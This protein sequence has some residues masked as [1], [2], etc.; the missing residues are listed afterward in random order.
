[1]AASADDLWV[2]AGFNGQA[3]RLDPS[4]GDVGESVEI[5]GIDRLSAAGDTLWAVSP[6]EDAA[7]RVDAAT[8]RVAVRAQVC[9]S[10]VAVA[11]VPDDGGAWI[12]CSRERTLWHLDHAGSV[13]LEV[14]LDGVPTDLALDGDRVWVT[15][16]E[17]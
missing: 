1:V 7:T 9:D 11:A 8:S 2:A 16:R 15:L 6:T 4:S 17:D 5:P 14:P 13:D 3:V 12:V 10:P